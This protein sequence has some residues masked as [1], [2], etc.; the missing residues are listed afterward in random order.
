VCVCVSVCLSHTHGGDTRRICTGTD[1]GAMIMKCLAANFSDNCKA[2]HG[3]AIVAPDLTDVRHLG[4]LANA[5]LPFCARKPILLERREL[6]GL[7]STLRYLVSGSGECLYQ[8][9]LFCLIFFLLFCF[10]C[11]CCCCCHFFFGLGFCACM[12]VFVWLN[13]RFVFIFFWL[14]WRE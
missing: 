6:K 5:M 4:Q 14:N 7:H 3:P 12:C 10:V 8:H 11:Y 2:I 13:W 1:W 9:E